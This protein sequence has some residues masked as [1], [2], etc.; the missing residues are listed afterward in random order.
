[1]TVA[2]LVGRLGLDLKEDQW[3]K[4]ARLVTGLHASMELLKGAVGAAST[5]VQKFVGDMLAAGD[6]ADKGSKA[7]GISAAEYQELA[8][9]AELSGVSLEQ[10][11]PALGALA[12]SAAA[13]RDGNAQMARSFEALGVSATDASGSLKDPITLL[14]EMAGGLSGVESQSERVVLMQRLMSESGARLIPMLEGGADGLRAMRQEAR[15]L[16]IVIDSEGVAQT[17]ALTDGLARLNAGFRGLRNIIAGPLI[18][19]IQQAVDAMIAWW[20]ANQ[21]II[22]QRVE[23]AFAKM[24]PVLEATGRAVLG[25]VSA[26]GWLADRWKQLAFILGGVVFVALMANNGALAVQIGLWLATQAAAVAAAIA[27]AGAWLL[28]ALPI[29]ALGAL[30]GVIAEDIYQFATGGESLLGDFVYAVGE[31]WTLL[32]KW[33]A[34]V[35]RDI[36]ASVSSAMDAASETVSSAVVRVLGKWNE[37][38][39]GIEVFATW[40]EDRFGVVRDVIVRAFRFAIDALLNPLRVA[41]SLIEKL[42]GGD[43]LGGLLT[44]AASGVGAMFG[45]GAQSPAAS[46]GM[47]TS[48]T[49][50]SRNTNISAPVE[51]RVTAAPGQS[52]EDVGRAVA[53]SMGDELARVLSDAAATAGA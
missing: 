18:P 7:L 30:L 16:G 12:R 52:T 25:L 40:M 44:G 50:S 47:S 31:L 37:A 24:L 13:A 41:G 48:T 29:I 33:A 51:V 32:G 38:K 9:A 6:A 53:G 43:A 46:A 15:D 10:L 14:E 22:R 27:A 35:W 2:E 28:V 4:G 19:V 49:N 23:D 20:L 3:Q 45:G 21:Q 26:I 39:A 8:H 1:M 5:I 17:V 36:T 42:P 11:R 34:D